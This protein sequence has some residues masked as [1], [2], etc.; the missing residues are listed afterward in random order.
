[1]HN[2]INNRKAKFWKEQYDIQNIGSNS[3][4]FESCLM[5]RDCFTKVQLSETVKN[6]EEKIYTEAS[7]LE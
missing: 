6:D 1:M 3:R 5:D 2:F 4:D 7:K